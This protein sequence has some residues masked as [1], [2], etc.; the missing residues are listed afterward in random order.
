MG[1]DVSFRECIADKATGDPKE[2]L[3]EWMVRVASQSDD[4]KHASKHR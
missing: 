1:F 4:L 2:R 3:M